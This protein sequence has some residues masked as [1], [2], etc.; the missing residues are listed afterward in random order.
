LPLL[1]LS[2]LLEDHAAILAAMLH[3]TLAVWGGAAFLAYI[4]TIIGF[5]LWSFLL[6]QHPA[7]QVTPFSLLVPVFGMSAAALVYHEQLSGRAMLGSLIVLAGL[8]I[9]VFARRNRG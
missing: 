8:G 2:L 5:G 6:S 9:S 3:P 4:A 7:A 1:V